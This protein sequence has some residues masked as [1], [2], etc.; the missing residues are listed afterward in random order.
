MRDFLA[1]SIDSI[2]HTT[3]PLLCTAYAQSETAV[4]LDD[5]FDANTPCEVARRASAAQGRA[6]L[7]LLDRCFVGRGVQAQFA[8]QEQV[9]KHVQALRAAIRDRRAQGHFGVVYGLTGLSLGIDLD[10]LVYTFVQAHAKAVLSAA[11]R[12]SLLG[13]YEMTEVLAS[14]ETQRLI[15]TAIDDTR[16]LHPDEVCQ[17]HSLLDIYQGRH[18]LLYS[19]IFNA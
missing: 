3:V 12:L 9:A 8:E 11:V 17:T 13:P 14:P 5:V 4:E 10:S 2:C 16:H 18:T 6:L 15:T 19:R 1:H 7:K